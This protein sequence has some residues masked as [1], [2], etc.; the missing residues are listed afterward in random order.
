[1]LASLIG[2]AVGGAANIASGWLSATAQQDAA[3][4]MREALSQAIT[5]SE[6]Y[7]SS[8]SRQERERALIQFKR[9]QQAERDYW[10]KANQR[11]EADL[12]N[13]MASPMYQQAA[14]YLQSLFAEGIPTALAQDLAGRVR[15]AQTARGLESGGAAIQ[16]ESRYLSTM[17]AQQRQALL[18]QLQQMALEPTML[19]QQLSSGY[20]QN[21]GLAQQMGLA[22]SAG[23]TAGLTAAEQMAASRY[24]TYTNILGSLTQQMPYSAA[25]PMANA[26]LAAGS[27]A[28]K[29]G[30]GLDELFASMD[31]DTKTKGS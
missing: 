29:L 27:T 18:P 31:K 3:K 30:F 19:R 1:M 26:L 5:E 23:Q 11:T 20:L 8:E 13:A 17:A 21:M 10:R 22:Q 16:N 12:F 15:S 6:Q 28:S 7:I 24:N 25:S 4:Q 2:G 14:G 9:A